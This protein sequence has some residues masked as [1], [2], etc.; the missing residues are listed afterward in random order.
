MHPL[1]QSIF[2]VYMFRLHDIGR[3]NVT[4]EDV[5]D[6]YGVSGLTAQHAHPKLT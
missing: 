1:S 5:L 2:V 3:A 6:K 4:I